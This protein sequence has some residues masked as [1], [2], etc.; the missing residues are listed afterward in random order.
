MP[1]PN[2]TSRAKEAVHK[3]HQLAVERGQS[4][5]NPLHLLAAI[6]LQD[7]NLT[8]S[9]F[10]QLGIDLNEILDSALD[11]LD[12]TAATDAVMAPSMQLF[13]TPE[14]A[15]ILQESASKIASSFNEQYVNTEHLTLAILNEPAEAAE[16]LLKY[17]LHKAEFAKLYKDIKDGKL[18]SSNAPVSSQNRALARYARFLTELAKENK[19]DPVIGRDLEIRRSMQI[20]SRRTKNNPVLIGEAGVGKTAIVEGIAQRIASGDVPES[21]QNKEI[22]M[23][24]LGLLVAGTKFRGEFEERLKAVLKE[25]ERSSGRIILFIDEIHT[26]VGT[27][28]AQDSLDLANL[29]KPALARGD[30]RVIGATTLGEYQKTIEKDPALG[31]RFQPVFVSEPS[32]KDSIAI[33]RGLKEKYEIY[34]G[35][36]VKDEAIVSA[37]ELSSRYIT[38]RFLPDKAVDLIDEAASALRLSLE[39]KPEKLEEAHR[40]IQ[41]LEMEKEAL[42]KDIKK[43]EDKAR[44]KLRKIE[45]ELAEIKDKSRDLQT[46]WQTEKNIL[47][48]IKRNKKEIDE[49]KHTAESKQ[50]E[51]DLSEAAQI[52]YVELPNKELELKRELERLAKLQKERRVLNEEIDEEDIASVVSRWTGVPV[53]K[54]LEDEMQKLKDMQ[55]TLKERVVGQDRAIEKVAN[56]VKRARAGVS[57]PNKPIASFI[58]LGPTGVGKTELT[59]ALAEFMFNSEDAL[60]R[61]DMSEFMEKHS[62]SKM[63]GSPPGYVGHEEGGELTEKV[64][65]RPYSVILFDEVEKAHPEVFNILLQVLDTGFLKDAKGRLVNFRN[66]IIILTSNLGAKH[67]QNMTQLGF[68][69]QDDDGKNQYEKSKEKVLKELKDFFRPEFLNRIDEIVLFD[70]LSKENIEKIV[71]LELEKLKKRLSRRDINL[72]IGK[73]A[74]KYIAEQAYDP[75]LGARPV[76]RYIEDKLAT[77]IAKLIIEDNLQSPVSLSVAANKDGIKIK[78]LKGRSRRSLKSSN[79]FNMAVE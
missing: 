58:F 39:S 63:I 50:N 12:N 9:I 22:A 68:N 74:I 38:D 67:I 19:L 79:E 55:K 11:I 57:D 65:H 5:V 34:H 43:G 6:L 54:M 18:D 14:L 32:I 45:K 78:T 72:N 66:S 62:V 40:K 44:A 48:K 71:T 42:K 31:R 35:I 76:K 75:A 16:L 15:H 27:G 10:E 26:I 36:R 46:R 41:Q 7:E 25:V 28:S 77:E 29:L 69:L 17:K 23:L 60:L 13:L 47:D 8:L 1:F 73:S 64:R 4:H 59:K 2:F 33:L 20:L 3:A 24:D 37:V 70:V 61:V 53:N 52:R 21:L 30:L 49:L 56:A 51:G